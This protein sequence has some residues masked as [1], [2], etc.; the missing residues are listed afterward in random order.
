[1]VTPPVAVVTG[2]KGRD[3]FKAF[4]K[5]LEKINNKFT[6]SRSSVAGLL[7]F[8]EKH[9]TSP[10]P[11]TGQNDEAKVQ[12]ALG[13][14]QNPRD[15]R[16][17]KYHDAI[18]RMVGV[19]GTNRSYPTI[20]VA[21]V[22][23]SGNRDKDI[24][25]ACRVC[26]LLRDIRITDVDFSGNVRQAAKQKLVDGSNLYDFV[27]AK[28]P[29]VQQQLEQAM[30]SAKGAAGARAGLRGKPLLLLTDLRGIA[31][32]VKKYKFAVCESI[33]ATVIF[34]CKKEGF[35][36]RLEWIGIKY[37]P[38]PE[39][40]IKVSITGHSIVVAHRQGNLDDVSTWGNYFII[41][42][43]YYNLGMKQRYLWD[44]AAR[45]RYHASEIGRLKLV[46]M[47]DV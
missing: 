20:H 12:T 37:P 36:G 14:C 13:K 17:I 10:T 26:E 18:K 33:A 7:D 45:E 46:Q 47:A 1:V 28:Y 5:D 4:L 27:K 9:V 23:A 43:W 2:E 16:L 8:L 25:I 21:G 41:D 40:K 11:F 32:S 6:R 30:T 24:E 29:A 42:L 35:A 44:G 3:H 19:W 38:K 31:D 15:A 39:E 22:V 34:D